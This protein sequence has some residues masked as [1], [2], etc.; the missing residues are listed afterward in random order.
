LAEAQAARRRYDRD[1]DGLNMGLL[2]MTLAAEQL[3][4]AG[5]L[6]PIILAKFHEVAAAQDKSLASLSDDLVLLDS[7]LDSLCFAIIVATLEDQLGF[8]PF[9]QSEDAVFPL[10][11]GDF[12]RFYDDAR[13]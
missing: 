5:S 3:L 9:T 7:G 12:V 10:T 2:S 6:R 8:D 4:D 13:R 1:E 11:L